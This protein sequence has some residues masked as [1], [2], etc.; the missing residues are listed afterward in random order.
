MRAPAA[1][2]VD[3]CPVYQRCPAAPAPLGTYVYQAKKSAFEFGLTST[4][5]PYPEV[6][7]S[8]QFPEKPKSA[9]VGRALVVEHV[10]FCVRRV[11]GMLP[12]RP[13]PSVKLYERRPLVHKSK[14][15]VAVP[16]AVDAVTQ[17]T[18]R[19]T[20]GLGVCPFEAISERTA[21]I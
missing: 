14:L 5:I 12:V 15:I 4:V 7:G 10:T 8:Y 21:I 13:E 11:N 19:L 1:K 3:C 20:H 18:V 6:A 16:T 9:F 17:A 2:G